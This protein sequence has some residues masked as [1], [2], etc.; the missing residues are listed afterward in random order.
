L[1]EVNLANAPIRKAALEAAAAALEP[2][3]GALI[4]AGVGSNDLAHIA[5]LAF[6]DAAS[7]RLQLNGQRPSVSRIAAAIGLTRADV[8]QL[9]ASQPSTMARL[10]WAPRAADKVVAGWLNDPDFLAPDGSPRPLSYTDA[11]RGFPELV[12]RY[13]GGIPPRAM[14]NELLDTRTVREAGKNSYLP[15]HPQAG[16][17]KSRPES[18]ASFGAKLNAFGSTLLANLRAEPS[19][20]QFEALIS[21]NEVPTESRGK[22]SRDLERRCRTFAQAVERYLLDQPG[23]GSSPSA[24]S[25]RRGIGV[26]IAVVGDDDN[27]DVDSNKRAEDRER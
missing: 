13:S 3:V 19:Q 8:R 1:S 17:A 15:A 10:G 25:H 12:R 14:L 20:R 26:I 4:D 6:V 27:D 22:I 23:L 5:H 21:A 11:E 16:P 24:N 9:M 18:L 2:I 7:R